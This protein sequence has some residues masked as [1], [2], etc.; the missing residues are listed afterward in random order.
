MAKTAGDKSA[1]RLIFLPAI[2]AMNHLSYARKFVLLGVILLAPLA[3]LLRLQF[4]G[5]T[6]SVEFNAKESVGIEHIDPVKDL[7]HAIEK[8]RVFMAA[9]MAGDASFKNDLGAV[10]AEADAK[11][12]AVDI[13]DK[14]YGGAG[15]LK[16]SD[17]WAAIKSEW[18][19]LRAKG[20]ANAAEADAAHEAVSA[21]LVDLILNYSCNYS[22]LI[23][24]P[25]L[26]SY[27]LMDAWCTKMPI[28]G[29]NISSAAAGALRIST[30]TSA[31]RTL[32][33]AGTTRIL[34]A[35]TSDLLAVNMKTAFAETKSPKYG[36]SATLQPVL[37]GPTQQV[38]SQ[39]A[40]YADFIKTNILLHA[41]E[42]PPLAKGEVAAPSR[43]NTKQ[44]VDQALKALQAGHVLYEKL[45]PELDWLCKKRVTSYS[46]TRLQGLLLGASAAMLLIYVF[47]GF[48]LSVRTSAVALAGATTRM[49]AGTEEQFELDAKDELGEIAQSFN[50]IN[51]ALVEAR[52]L[53]RRVEKD[54]EE[55][56]ANIM[57]LLNVVSD[58]SDGD[59]R[60]RA[61][62]TAGALGNVS[63][64]F[65]NLLESQEGLISEILAQLSRTNEAVTAIALSS[66][67]MATGAT[68]QT[69]EVL[70]AM[71]LVQQMST[72][73]QRVSDNARTAAE[74]AKRTQDSAVEGAEG[75]HNVISGMGTLRANVQAGAKK[76]KNLGDRS[77]EIT[78]IVGTINRISEQTNMLALN[79][80]IEAARAGEHGR[81]FSVVAEEV[82]KLAERTAT[83]TQEIDKLVKAIHNE[84]TE[85][86]Q[87]IEQQTQFVEQESVLVGK[88]GESL[89][90]I[91]QVS[92]ESASLVADISKFASRQVEGTQAVVHTMGQISSIA[93]ATQ[94]GAEGTAVIVEQ[95]SSLSK[96]LTRSIG[97]FK[98]ANGA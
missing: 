23:L 26:D 21:M 50:Q 60:V 86:V 79:A 51:G 6:D 9:V 78:G 74:A 72:E 10:T 11:V 40:A 36:Q 98:L 57:D 35:T 63:D 5:T 84:T 19:G 87:A 66:Q 27:W 49:I 97:R 61:K 80:A 68:N 56:Q 2:T 48:Y 62:I 25:D 69:K 95:L 41:K 85:T 4:R 45:G 31:E 33:I 29:E 20:F 93:K 64:A 53:R 92:T 58:A 71:S 37:E 43:V 15:D 76:M 17:K 44:V 28:I 1:L 14:K 13:Q 55:L 12:G 90:R 59:L 32:E 81:G 46:S 3:F 83:A 39:V 67:T 38:G 82:R 47:A 42:A 65:N 18:A 88:A 16:T 30:E 7:L 34:T 73:I 91:S 22:N 24:D 96:Q 89:A 8:R 70:A 54:N 75:V 94:T 77:M 52:T